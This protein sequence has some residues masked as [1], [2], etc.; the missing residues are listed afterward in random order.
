MGPALGRQ[1]DLASPHS[2]NAWWSVGRFGLCVLLL[3]VALSLLVLPWVELSW[4]KVF[5]RCVSIAAA[6]SLWLSI[7]VFERRTFRSYGF[8]APKAGKRHLRFGV[9]LGVG[10]LAIFG[11]LGL[12][13]GA[14]QIDVTPDRLRLWRTLLGFLPVAGLI[15][16]LEEL[17][18]R[19]FILQHLRSISTPLAVIV[20]SAL[21]AVIHLKTSALTLQV[22]LELGGLFLLGGVLA[23]S[24]VLTHQLYLAVGLH[25]A[26]AYGARVNKLLMTF[27]EP[28]PSWLIGTSRLVNGLAGWGILLAIGA[29]VVWWA[30]DHARRRCGT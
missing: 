23:L 8:S 2:P 19:G 6:L 15:S 18:F 20:S 4:W 16:I 9:L 7:R 17:V 5:R 10:A 26:L 27:S 14:C 11:G 24:Y 25:A 13:S 3:S 1:R 28:V 30:R 12:I 21:Y 22:W 29:V